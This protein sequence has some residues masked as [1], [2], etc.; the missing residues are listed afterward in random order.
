MFLATLFI[1]ALTIPFYRYIHPVVPLIYIVAVGT[2]MEIIDK[3]KVQNPKFKMGIATGLVMFFAVGQTLGIL[4]LDSRFEKKLKNTG[5][6]PIYVEMSY[7]LKEITDKDDVIVTNLDTWGSW[8]GERKTIWFP[9]EPSMLENA[10]DEIDAIYLTSYKIDDQNYY[11]GK[12]WRI[13]FDNPQ[14]QVILSD[15]KFAGEY[16]FNALENFDNEEAR[17][18]LFVRK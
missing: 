2:L 14:N 5:K 11:M 3:F 13:L 15:F 9:L 16:R 18:I 1:T 10:G 7:K 12:N 8:Y 17:A 6:A 4:F